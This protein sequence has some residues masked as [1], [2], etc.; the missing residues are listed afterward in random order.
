MFAI[1]ESSITS[2]PKGNKGV[3]INGINILL[4][5][6]NMEVKVREMQ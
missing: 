5:I 3:E 4:Y 1:V 2:F 6:Y